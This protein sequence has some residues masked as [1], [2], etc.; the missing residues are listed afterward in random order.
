MDYRDQEYLNLFKK[1]REQEQEDVKITNQSFEQLRGNSNDFNGQMIRETPSYDNLNKPM[2]YN[3][4][5]N[6]NEVHR[7]P[8]GKELNINDFNVETRVNGQNINEVKQQ[9][10]EEKLNEIMQR[11]RE[12]K[13]RKLNEV[14]QH[15]EQERIKQE[16]EKLEKERLEK[17]RIEE[18]KREQERLEREKLNE[19]VNFKDSD[20][21]SVEMFEKARYNSMMLVANKIIPK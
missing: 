16:Q 13:E 19:T 4:Y 3:Q 1:V 17:Q 14:L 20:V 18:E 8:Y 10:K 5:Q 9:S 7:N 6:L 2:N 21:V 11:N 12:E 15:R